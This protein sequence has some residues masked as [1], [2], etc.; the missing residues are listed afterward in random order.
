[1]VLVLSLVLLLF[2]GLTG[3]ALDRAYRSSVE[4]G[5]AERLQIHVYL[6]L[7]ALERENGEFFVLETITEPRFSLMNSG[8]YGFVH[9]QAQREL[10]RSESGRML[11]PFAGQTNPVLPGVGDAVFDELTDAD[12]ATL[13]RFTYGIQWEGEAAPYAVSVLE[14]AA[15]YFAQIRDFRVSLGRWLGGAAVLL[16]GVLLLL[17]AW[18]LRP[19]VSLAQ[20]IS[21][22]EKGQ[23]DRV[24]GEY[25]DELA[26]VTHN[27]NRLIE[28]ERSQRERYKTTLAD[29]AHS[30]K[31]PLSVATGALRMLHARRGFAADAVAPTDELADIEQALQRMDKIVAYQ[32]QRAVASRPNSLLAERFEVKPA[33]ESLLSALAKVYAP[34]S[35]EVSNAVDPTLCFQGDERDLLEALGNLLDNAFK[36]AETRISIRSAV[37]VNDQRAEQAIIVIE[38]DGK[39]IAPEQRRFVLQRGARAD[40]LAAGQGIG[41][42]VVSDI[43]ASYSGSIEIDASPLGSLGGARVTLSFP[44]FT[45][46]A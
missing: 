10:W 46:S 12:N 22:I 30:L 41:L 13:F 4:S 15:P 19:L 29:L 8:L 38:D 7:A 32:L 42:A 25:P 44:Q 14:T 23:S 40:T 20:Q 24:R 21:L 35:V 27:L 31:T 43:V 1:M 17:L 11:L 45:S 37:R 26:G 6:L 3:L 9:D 2:L 36:H 18:G 16:L 39:G 33:V 5:A 28:T 34:R